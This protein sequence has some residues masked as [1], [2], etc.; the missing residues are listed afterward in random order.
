MG[1]YCL[2]K[3]KHEIYSPI[4]IQ[5]INEYCDCLSEFKPQKDSLD[6]SAIC[7]HLLFSDRQSAYFRW[8]WD[9][10]LNKTI[11]EK[12]EFVKGRENCDSLFNTHDSIIKK[13]KPLTVKINRF[14]VVK[15][16]RQVPKY[17]DTIDCNKNAFFVVYYKGFCVSDTIEIGQPVLN[18]ENWDKRFPLQ[19]RELRSDEME[20]FIDTTGAMKPVNERCNY[21]P[22]WIQNKS[23]FILQIGAGENVK[24]LC[25][26]KSTDG[27]VWEEYKSEYFQ[28][29]H[30]LKK[31]FLRPEEAVMTKLV[32]N[33]SEK[34]KVRLKFQYSQ[35]SVFYSNEVYP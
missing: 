23:P 9:T 12:N 8:Y 21:Y 31:L 32:V 3:N 17:T 30:N 18:F 11:F 25:L 34:N 33:K 5:A 14:S 35:K 10:T 6:I 20:I 13:V 22:V 2:Q 16:I 26:Y 19:N 1:F 15:Y 7:S 29:A 4:H 24:G 28:E 27:V